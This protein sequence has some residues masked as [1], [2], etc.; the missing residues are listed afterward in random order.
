MSETVSFE[1]ILNAALEK[2]YSNN[3]ISA[4]DV[5][6]ILGMLAGAHVREME[7]LRRTCVREEGR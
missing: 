5:A 6:A 2:V 1:S 4:I 7:E 3:E